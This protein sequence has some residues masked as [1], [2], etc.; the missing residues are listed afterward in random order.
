ML[1]RLVPLACA[2]LI[3]ACAG[4][5]NR[6]IKSIDQE[7]AARMLQPGVSTKAD[8]TRTYGAAKVNKFDSGYEV[9][10]YRDAGGWSKHTRELV[11]LF[12]PAGVVVKL[13]VSETPGED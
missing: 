3:A 10:T 8:V 7:T 4:G 5:G 9:W 13:R 1:R 12:N 11:F 6:M 2:S